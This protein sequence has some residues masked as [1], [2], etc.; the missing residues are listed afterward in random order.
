VYLQDLADFVAINPA[1]E[2]FTFYPLYVIDMSLL[3]IAE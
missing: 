1:I 2:G 3:S